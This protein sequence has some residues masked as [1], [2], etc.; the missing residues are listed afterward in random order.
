MVKFDVAV[1]FFFGGIPSKKE[2]VSGGRKVM[3]SVWRYVLIAIVACI[4]LSTKFRVF[5]TKKRIEKNY[6]TTLRFVREEMYNGK[7]YLIFCD[8]IREFTIEE[9]GRIVDIREL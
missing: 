5:I 3:E 1:R 6:E 4:C 9:N 2:R 7:Y 8:D